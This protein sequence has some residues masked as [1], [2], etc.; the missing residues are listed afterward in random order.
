MTEESKK[1]EKF[2]SNP[3]DQYTNNALI[4]VSQYS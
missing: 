3:Y 4:D 2:A 1:T